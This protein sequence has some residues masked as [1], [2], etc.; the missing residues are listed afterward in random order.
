MTFILTFCSLFTQL[1]LA[2]Y[3]YAP[4]YLG[5]ILIPM[6]TLS[7]FLILRV[8]RDQALEKMVKKCG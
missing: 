3:N 7:F 4:Y 6:G 5:I 2:Y 8:R 1:M